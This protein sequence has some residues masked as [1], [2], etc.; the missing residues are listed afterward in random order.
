MCS[1]SRWLAG[2]FLQQ[3]AA[4]CLLTALAC[5]T[6]CPVMQMHASVTSPAPACPCPSPRWIIINKGFPMDQFSEGPLQFFIFAVT[7]LVGRR[8]PAFC[9][10]PLALAP[11][12]ILR[13]AVAAWSA[14]QE[15]QPS[16][17]CSGPPDA[18][19]APTPSPCSRAASQVVAV[20]EGL[21]LAVTISLAY[22]M[23]K[24]MKDNNFVRVLAACETMVGGGGRQGRTWEAAGPEAACSKV[25]ALRCAAGLVQGRRRERFVCMPGR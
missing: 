24:M 11:P 22:S 18:R 16:R 13:P 10:P 17:G 2:P 15:M 6:A 23:K 14:W 25:V 9:P 1:R 7:I 20:P 4:E 21:P 3:A 19:R 8:C 12:S 5:I